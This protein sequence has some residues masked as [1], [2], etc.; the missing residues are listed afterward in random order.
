[1]S[2]QQLFAKQAYKNRLNSLSRSIRIAKEKVSKATTASEQETLRQQVQ[3]W[4]ARKQ[5]FVSNKK[6]FLSLSIEEL[7]AA[8]VS[9]KEIQAAY[10]KERNRL[11]ARISWNNKHGKFKEAQ[12]LKKELSELTIDSFAETMNN[13]TTSR[14]FSFPSGTPAPPTMASTNPAPTFGSGTPNPFSFPSGT[15]TMNPAPTTPSRL[16]DNG[17]TNPFSSPSGTPAPPTNPFSFP[18]G[19]PAPPTNPFSSPSGTPAPPTNP[20]SSPSGTPVPPPAM[21]STMNPAPTTPGTTNHGTTTPFSFRFATLAPPTNHF[22]SPPAMAP[23]NPAMA[24]TP[25]NTAMASTNPAVLDNSGTMTNGTD[26]SFSFPPGTPVPATPSRRGDSIPFSSPLAG[27]KPIEVE[28]WA[29]A[30]YLSMKAQRT[31]EAKQQAEAYNL[32]VKQE[33]KES[34]ATMSMFTR[35]LDIQNEK[36]KAATPAVA[37]PPAVVQVSSTSS[38]SFDSL[39]TFMTDVEEFKSEA[40]W[41]YP[42]QEEYNK[43]FVAM[44]ASKPTD[45][46]IH[47]FL[48]YGFVEEH[49]LNGLI[50]SAVS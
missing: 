6:Q 7:E 47:R 8:R 9:Q 37:V 4:E 18:S 50:G 41:H 28:E 36:K 5:A 33:C 32:R 17:T 21:A 13:N 42:S 2:E 48:S 22:S 3:T 19:T 24:P 10:A 23:T 30:T 49:F 45:Y 14:V 43:G 1:M 40:V 12:E 44:I 15:P 16:F 25:T 31:E 26:G 29:C 27:M 46:T 11:H 39:S 38:S 20:F 35:L 34:D